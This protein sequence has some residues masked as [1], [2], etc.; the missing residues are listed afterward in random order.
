MEYISNGEV[1]TKLEQLK[2]ALLDAMLTSPPEEEGESP[3]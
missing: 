3:L 2:P 1:F